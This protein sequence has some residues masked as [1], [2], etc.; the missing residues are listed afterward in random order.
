MKNY[1]EELALLEEAHSTLKAEHARLKEEHARLQKEHGTLVAELAA[2]KEGREQFV[3]HDGVL[4]KR[5]ASGFETH[6]YCA[7]CP[8][9]AVMS[10]MHRAHKFVC[11]GG[12]FAPMSARPPSA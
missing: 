10:P 9:P 12:H 7:Q 8:R 3:P 6:P 4:W 11:S 2:L 1:P 5:T